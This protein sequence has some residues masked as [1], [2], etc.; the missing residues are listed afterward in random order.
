MIHGWAQRFIVPTNCDN[1]H[2][3]LHL[4]RYVFSGI[5]DYFIV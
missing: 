2:A 3:P 4:I 5:D 1:L